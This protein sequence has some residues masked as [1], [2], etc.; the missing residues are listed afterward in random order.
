MGINC[1]SCNSNKPVI[2]E[3]METP[4]PITPLGIMKKDKKYVQIMQVGGDEID[5]INIITN[6]D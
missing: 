3:H 6:F 1:N 5:S 4:C 2:T